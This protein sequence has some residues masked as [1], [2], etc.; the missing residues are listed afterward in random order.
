MWSDVKKALLIVWVTVSL[1]LAAAAVVPLAVPRPAI[2]RLAPRCEAKSRLGRE[3]FLCGMTTAFLEIARGDFAASETANRASVPA[4]FGFLS[5][6][7][8]TAFVLLR[9]FL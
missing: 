5:N 9:R 6:A 7:A 2:V 1:T 4:Y 3:W 8:A